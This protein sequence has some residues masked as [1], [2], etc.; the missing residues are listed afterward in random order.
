MADLYQEQ[1]NVTFSTLSLGSQA[2]VLAVGETGTT[3]DETD[4]LHYY[5]NQYS[6]QVPK[7]T[8]ILKSS[9]QFPMFNQLPITLFEMNE[10]RKMPQMP[11]EF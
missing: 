7:N 9:N 1:S 5:T 11:F 4:A 3:L 2:A 10:H 8:H 6:Y